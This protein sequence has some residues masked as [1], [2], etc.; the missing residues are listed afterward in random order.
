MVFGTIASLAIGAGVAAAGIGGAAIAASG[1]KSAAKAQGKALTQA[2]T[3]ELEFLREVRE[4]EAPLREAQIERA[5][6]GTSFFPGLREMLEAP[7][8]DP[9][10]RLNLRE[11]LDAIKSTSAVTGS[12]SS[13]P[14]Q[15]AQ[16]RFAAGVVGQE[17]IRRQ[18][19][20]L[21]L[22][23]IQGTPFPTQTPS[24]AQFGAAQAEA[25]GQEAG[26]FGSTFGPTVSQLPVQLSL[27]AALNRIK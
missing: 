18:N 5:K 17:N 25:A 3:A 22:A 14:S 15:I 27:M 26:A 12:P 23:G 6:F 20:A 8:V 11:G 10:F 1:A 2:Q 9:G 21:A 24:F 13:G 7:E 19:L 16:G 4:E